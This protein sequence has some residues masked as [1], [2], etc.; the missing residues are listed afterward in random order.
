MSSSI[1][2]LD[3]APVAAVAAAPPVVHRPLPTADK[4]RAAPPVADPAA[5]GLRPALAP[6]VS[7]PLDM[8]PIDAV[9]VAIDS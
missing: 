3:A 1:F 7:A 2:V 4:A 9:P 8:R 5:V 6:D